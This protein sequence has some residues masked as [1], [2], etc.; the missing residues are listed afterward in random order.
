MSEQVVGI[1]IELG[2]IEPKIWRRVQLPLYVSLATLHDVIEVAFDWDGSHMAGFKIG[3]EF[4]IASFGWG[5][6]DASE[7]NAI[8]LS[9]QDVMNKRTKGIRY[10]YDFGESWEHRITFGK[11]KFIDTAMKAPKLLG[12]ARNAPLEDYG[13]IWTYVEYVNLLSDPEEQ[14]NREYDESDPV[15]WM[16]EKEYDPEAFD[17]EQMSKDLEKVTLCEPYV[18]GDDDEIID[19][20]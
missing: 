13:G 15:S 1:R 18:A 5:D 8:E 7:P 2:Y 6:Y 12:G 9:L 14:K 10:I 20:D 16:I 4:Y 19:R 11:P 3:T 17:E